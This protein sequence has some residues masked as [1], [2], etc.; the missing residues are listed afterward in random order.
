MCEARPVGHAVKR[1]GVAAI[2]SLRLTA[3]ATPRASSVGAMCEARP[4]GHAVKRE[5][6]VAIGSFRLTAVAT[7]RALSVGVMCEAR[8]VGHA[9]KRVGC[10]RYRFASFNRGG[11]AP[12]VECWGDV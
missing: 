4:A 12:R 5:G 10:C 6:V 8:P 3:V 9:V 7:P 2:G 11:N 1:E